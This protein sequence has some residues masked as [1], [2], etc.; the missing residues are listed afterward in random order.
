MNIVI[1]SSHY[2]RPQY[3]AKSVAAIASQ[4]EASLLHYIASVDKS[5]RQDEVIAAI[6]QYRSSFKAIREY[7]AVVNI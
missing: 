4:P 5:D 6:E 2:R 1:T 3:T 7:N